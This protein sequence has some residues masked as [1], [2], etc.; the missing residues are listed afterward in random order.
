[1]RRALRSG[2]AV[3]ALLVSL[4]IVPAAVGADPGGNSDATKAC[5]NGVYA[6]RTCTDGTR[7]TNTG[8]CVNDVARGGTLVRLPDLQR[9][10]SCVPDAV[11]HSITCTFTVTNIGVAPAIGSSILLQTLMTVPQVDALSLRQFGHVHLR[12]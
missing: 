11:N 2:I 8:A 10:T 3:F 9:S 6:N 4:F 12:Q 1:M 7:C 5:Q